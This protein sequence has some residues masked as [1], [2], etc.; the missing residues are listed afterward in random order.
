MFPMLEE[1][2]TVCTDTEGNPI[3]A[4]MGVCRGV[5]YNKDCGVCKDEGK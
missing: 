1:P 5:E 3:L 2:P 4:E